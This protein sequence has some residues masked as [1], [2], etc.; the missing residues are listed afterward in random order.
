MSEILPTSDGLF[1]QCKEIDLAASRILL[2][3]LK[4]ARGV[5]EF[6]REA[7]A[8]NVVPQTIDEGV[9]GTEHGQKIQVH[10]VPGVNSNYAMS[11]LNEMVA[12][13]AASYGVP[14]WKMSVSSTAMVPSGAALRELNR[15]LNAARQARIEANRSNVARKFAIET[16]L[17]SIENGSA[18]APGAVES[19][20]PEEEP[21]IS[22]RMADLQAAQLELQMGIASV[23]DIA[24]SIYPELDT[25]EKLMNYMDSVRAKAPQPAPAPASGVARLMGPRAVAQ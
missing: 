23:D 5:Y 14:S 11:I 16:A 17:C 9:V 6:N 22:D 1:R 8:S 10:H 21:I 4:S 18:V 7:G 25:E 3:T 24:A 15:P 13:T 2:S 12:H 20:E 19:W